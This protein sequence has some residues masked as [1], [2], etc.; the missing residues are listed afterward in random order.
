MGYLESSQT[1]ALFIDGMGVF[2]HINTTIRRQCYPDGG[3][4][5]GDL[6]K[7]RGNR[8]GDCSHNSLNAQEVLLDSVTVC[9]NKCGLGQCGGRQAGRAD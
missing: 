3:D 7:S 6:R 5:K 9:N 8:L 2:I 1:A 4:K